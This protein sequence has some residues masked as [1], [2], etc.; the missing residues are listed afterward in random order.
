MTVGRP[1]HVHQDA[2]A[3]RRRR[4]HGGERAED[5]YLVVTGDEDSGMGMFSFGD[6]LGSGMASD[7]GANFVYEA[8]KAIQKVEADVSALLALDTKPDNLDTILEG[9]W[10]QLHMALDTIF[11]TDQH[12]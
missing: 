2:D 6:L 11:G 4:R 1:W 7:E 3:E 8:V 9:Q 5:A 10:D 12:C